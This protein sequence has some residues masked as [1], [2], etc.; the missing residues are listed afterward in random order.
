MANAF[1]I[2]KSVAGKSIDIELHG[3]NAVPKVAEQH[4][5]PGTTHYQCVD[6]PNYVAN[7]LGYTSWT[8]QAGSALTGN[9]N[10]M[11]NYVNRANADVMDFDPAKLQVGDIVTLFN[12]PYGHVYIYGGG[13][14]PRITVAEQNFANHPYVDIHT[15]DRSSF[16][17]RPLSIIRFK[18]QTKAEG[19]SGATAT[20]NTQVKVASL[21][22]YEITCEK[23]QGT[24]KPNGKVIDTFYKCNKVVGK[25]DGNYLIYNKYTGEKGYIPKSCVEEK[26]SYNN[27]KEGG[28]KP[29]D[30]VQGNKPVPDTNTVQVNQ[31]TS[32]AKYT[33]EQFIVLGRIEWGGYEWTYYSQRVLP[34]EG[35]NI[36]GRHVNAHG[37]VADKD[38]YIV[39]A[40]PSSWGNVKGNIY[41]TPFGYKG[42]V[43]DVNSGGTSLDV[44][45][46]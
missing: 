12:D 31:P 4:P 14:Y 1:D 32:E 22:F 26:T 27:Q 15:Y 33:L 9:G 39:L 23:V 18:N 43:Y 7:K 21:T 30:N 29:A 8:G 10:D 17:E 16:G 25:I 35:L 46:R 6:L 13:T 37:Y 24:D 36:P 41:D 5:Y 40:A 42:K 2:A 19:V 28:T 38:G 44:Y 34:G 11:Q 3:F 45:I 20:N